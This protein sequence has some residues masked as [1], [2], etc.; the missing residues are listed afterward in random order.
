MILT[1]KDRL[2]RFGSEIIFSLCEFFGVEVELIEEA[3]SQS[4]EERLSKDVIELM[5][6]FCARLH[7]SRA[8][9]KKKKS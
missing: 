9:R 5:V 8:H 2:L 7:G 4:L 3:P 1:H 6:V